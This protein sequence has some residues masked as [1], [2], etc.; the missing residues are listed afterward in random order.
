MNEA[1]A[2]G[3]S[4]GQEIKEA[5]EWNWMGETIA[6][7]YWK[8]I[9]VNQDSITLKPTYDRK[10]GNRIVFFSDFPLVNYSLR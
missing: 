4:V 8:V 2:R 10:M 5:I 9:K 1:Q 3:L 7:R 6:H